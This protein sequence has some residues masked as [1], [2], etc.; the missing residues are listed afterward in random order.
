MGLASSG[1]LFVSRTMKIISDLPGVQCMV[2]NIVVAA[3]TFSQLI[4]RLYVLFQRL[5]ENNATVSLKNL[6][7]P[8]A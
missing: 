8:A 1:D 2:D 4:H 7:Y 5:E 6:R 3:E